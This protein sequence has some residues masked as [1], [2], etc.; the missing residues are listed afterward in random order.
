VWPMTGARDGNGAAPHHAAGFGIDRL[1]PLAADNL[2]S[3]SSAGV[4]ESM[5]E[6]P[7][8]IPVGERGRLRT[9]RIFLLEV[10]A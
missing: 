2:G 6:R 3:L 4:E 8:A 1:G 5:A 9:S 10:N 7:Y